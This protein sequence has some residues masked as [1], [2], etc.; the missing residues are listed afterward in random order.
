MKGARCAA[1]CLQWSAHEDVTEK[2]TREQNS[3]SW[4]RH[5]RTVTELATRTQRYEAKEKEWHKKERAR[6]EKTRSSLSVSCEKVDPICERHSEGRSCQ[7]SPSTDTR[8]VS[9]SEASGRGTLH[10]DVSLTRTSAALGPFDVR[11]DS[12]KR[13]IWT[14]T[15]LEGLTD[16]VPT[17]S[18]TTAAQGC[19]R[20]SFPVK[21][22]LS[23]L[24]L[25]QEKAKVTLQ[26]V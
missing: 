17:E 16:V 3:N 20:V 24:P 6:G 4:R 21:A 14:R 5:E 10:D 2:E 9:N 22:L 8:G 23:D 15:F 7:R 25:K 1:K 12:S 11:L 19:M 26:L 18:S 13:R